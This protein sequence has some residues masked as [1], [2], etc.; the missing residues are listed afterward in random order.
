MLVNVS[1][2]GSITRVSTSKP[3]R[4]SCFHCKVFRASMP[5]PNSLKT[6]SGERLFSSPLQASGR[7][8]GNVQCEKMLRLPVKN[9]ARV[10]LFWIKP[11]TLSRQKPR[12]LDFW[13]PKHCSREAE[14][15]FGESM[16]MG[17]APK[18]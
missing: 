9:E 18:H 10:T 1:V 2:T 17:A 14:E 12:N 5:K 4:R 7:S 11:Q 15:S 3:Q 8:Q 16:L 13:H 6:K